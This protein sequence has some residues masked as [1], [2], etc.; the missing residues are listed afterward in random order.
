MD[1]A[2]SSPLLAAYAARLS[3]SFS[4]VIDGSACSSSFALITSL[5]SLGWKQK[6]E[7]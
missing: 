7:Q 6:L 1:V 4:S 2:L 5:F 3:L